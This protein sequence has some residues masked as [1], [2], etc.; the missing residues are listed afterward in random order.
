[1]SGHAAAS[2]K[3]LD[4]AVP[5]EHAVEVSDPKRPDNPHSVQAVEVSDPTGNEA[6]WVQPK[7]IIPLDTLLARPASACDTGY[8]LSKNERAL[9]GWVEQHSPCCAAASIAGAFNALRGVSSSD[10]AAT[11]ASQV[12]GYLQA[13]VTAELR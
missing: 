12:L 6:V 1:M 4:D 3:R 10:E 9:N 13:Q 2:R 7:I 5:A 8:R 11:P